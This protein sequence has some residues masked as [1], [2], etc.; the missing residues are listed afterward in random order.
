MTDFLSRLEPPRLGW[1]IVGMLVAFIAWG[2]F[3]T[4]AFSHRSVEEQRWR[5]AA[6]SVEAI[7]QSG[8][9]VWIQPRDTVRRGTR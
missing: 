4:V 8:R 7:L 6:D 5:A 3:G 9:C 1:L 2:A